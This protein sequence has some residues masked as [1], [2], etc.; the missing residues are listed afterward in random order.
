PRSASF[1][2]VPRRA[3]HWKHPSPGSRYSPHDNRDRG[4]RFMATSSVLAFWAVA[5]LFAIVPG[6]DWAFT[7]SAAL[8]GHRVGT[9]VGGLV[10]GYTVLTVI[11]AAGVRAMVAGAPAARPRLTSVGGGGPA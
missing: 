3:E 8:R 9:A 5:V 7:I 6:T 11:V 10:V 1:A 4:N 2:G